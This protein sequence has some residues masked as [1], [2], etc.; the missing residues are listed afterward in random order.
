METQR[1][2]GREERAT[3]E[4]EG[5]GEGVRGDRTIEREIKEVKG[6]REKRGKG[7]K[8]MKERGEHND[9]D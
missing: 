8:R 7:E 2:V 4:L 9:R 5:G 1:P 6:G 3:N